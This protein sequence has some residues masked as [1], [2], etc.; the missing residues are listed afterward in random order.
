MVENTT[1][2]ILKNAILLEKRGKAF[3]SKV[4]DETK[5]DAVKRFF[6]MMANEEENHIKILSDQ[7]KAYQETQ[8]FHPVNYEGKHSGSLVSEI[9][10]GELK[11][12]ISAAEFEAAAI[13]AAMAMEKNAIR[14]YSKRAEV[15][16]DPD[17]KALYS[18]LAGWEH[19]HL[20]FL[21][22][23]DRQLTED[24]WYDNS[25]WPF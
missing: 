12:Q 8:S 2:D 20:N 13:S 17:E 24:I 16:K 3:Y 21:A 7:F 23:I 15:T 25:F 5:S 1:M 19:Q 11:E 10:T 9:L 14:L 22:E 18:W 4:A 6:S